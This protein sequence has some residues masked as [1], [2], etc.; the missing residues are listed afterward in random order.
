MLGLEGRKDGRKTGRGALSEDQAHKQ[1][2]E[3]VWFAGCHSNIGDSTHRALAA[4][5]DR[6]ESMSRRRRVF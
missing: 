3:Q 6:P 1:V 4:A 5:S 2:L